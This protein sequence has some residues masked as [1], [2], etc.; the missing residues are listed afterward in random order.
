MLY[1]ISNKY[2]VKVGKDFVE[3]ELVYSNNDISLKPTNNKIENDGNVKYIEV[4]FLSEKDNLL[5]EHKK[6]NNSF[7]NE[8][9]FTNESK[10]GTG[11][12]RFN[13]EYSE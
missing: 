6:K 5:A 12:Y 13:D 7:T 8:D 4:N 1:K 2:Y 3:V 10:K 11:K 9:S